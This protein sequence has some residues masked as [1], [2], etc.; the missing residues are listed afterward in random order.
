MKVKWSKKYLS[1]GITAFFVVAASILFL[2]FLLKFD[3][4]SKWVGTVIS[5]LMPIILGLAF[6]YL[7]NPVQNFFENTCYRRLFKNL[8]AKKPKSKLPRILS[9]TTAI[10]VALLVIGGLIGIML[11]QLITSVKGLIDKMPGYLANFK[12][13]LDR[14]IVENHWLASVVGENSDELITRLQ[15][16]LEGALPA[17]QEMAG[18]VTGVVIGGAI[19]VVNA[20][21]DFILGLVVSIYVMY[22]KERFAA[23]TKKVMYALFPR[24]YTD[25]AIE[26]TRSTNKV[27]GGFISGKLIEALIIGLMTF[28]VM[29]ILQIPYAPLISVIVGITD[30]IPFFG[31]FIGAIP[32]TLI[33]LLEDPFKAVLFVIITIIIQQIDGNLIGPKILGDS[34]GLSAFWVIFAIL[35]GGGLFGFVGMLLGVP[36]WAV[37]YSL[38]KAFIEGRLERKKFPVSTQAYYRETAAPSEQTPPP[39]GDGDGQEP[40]EQTT[41]AEQ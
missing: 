25:R 10:L 21:T 24:S 37:I 19:G 4:V 40:A 32:S 39:P 1:A 28:I 7:L 31:P 8:L 30:I 29:A 14:M 27:F 13:W 41:A 16:S 2:L 38:I 3:V 22:S 20:V 11:P 23:Q 6:A 5:I 9:V 12:E 35:L 26:L 15:K 36:A 34:T 18:N 33:L 17:L